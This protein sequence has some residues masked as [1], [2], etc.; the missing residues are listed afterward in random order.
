[1]IE[2]IAIAIVAL[3]V[4]YFIGR[5]HEQRR[6]AAVIRRLGRF[7]ASISPE[8]QARFG[9]EMQAALRELDDR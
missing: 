5:V 3:F 4:G 1:M 7:A 2:G 9:Q 6:L 8:L